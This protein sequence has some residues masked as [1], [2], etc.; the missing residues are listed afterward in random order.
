M[1]RLLLSDPDPGGLNLCFP[2]CGSLIVFH[3][4]RES[5]RSR[6]SSSM[7]CTRWRKEAPRWRALHVSETKSTAIWPP[8]PSKRR[9]EGG[10]PRSKKVDERG[11]VRVRKGT[12][13]RVWTGWGGGEEA[14]ALP[15]WVLGGERALQPG[16]PGAGSS[17]T[18]M[19]R[20]VPQRTGARPEDREDG[21]MAA[22]GSP[23]GDPTHRIG[24]SLRIW[25]DAP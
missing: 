14:V 11:P 4:G 3:H 9:V 5:S 8:N 18:W 16:R 25:K 6:L 20:H 13:G 2:T 1:F 24:R 15:G 7:R 21:P 19:G 23:R 12:D 17:A 22:V 10:R